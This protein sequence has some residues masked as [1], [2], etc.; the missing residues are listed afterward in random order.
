MILDKIEN[1]GLYTAINARISKGFEYIK[2][3]DLISITSGKFEIGDGLT[4][5][6]SEYETKNVEDC[7]LE[8]HEKFIDIQYII[9]GEELIG[10]VPLNKQVPTIAYNSDRDVVFYKE[11]VALT[12]LEAGMFAVYFPT[13]LHQPCIKSGASSTVKKLVI[14]VLI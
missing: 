14:K 10:Y 12:K 2:T 8:A 9:S 5:I 11:E 7:N 6:I 13:D 4:A 3:T 1:A